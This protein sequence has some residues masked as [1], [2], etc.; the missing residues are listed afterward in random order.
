MSNIEVEY[1]AIV[2]ATNETLWLKG[3]YSNLYGVKSCITI[4]CD[5][6]S[7]VYLTKYQM[8]TKTTK[9]IDICYYFV[10]DNIEQGLVKIRKINTRDNPTNMMT[11]LV[12]IANFEFCSSLVG[13]THY[14]L[15]AFGV[16]KLMY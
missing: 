9:H 5:S 15:V 1:M 14:P 11:M 2:E 8:L 3:I 6:Q 10:R 13:V 4:Y 16:S 12:P 7:V